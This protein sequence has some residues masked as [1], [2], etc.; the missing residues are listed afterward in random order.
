[1][2]VRRLVLLLVLVLAGPAGAQRSIDQRLEAINQVLARQ[3][4][5]AGALLARGELHRERRDFERALADFAAAARALPPADTDLLQGMTLV[6]AGRAHQGLLYLDRHLA[7]HPGSALGYVE[8]A[9]A[10]EAMVAKEAAADDYQ[11]ALD[12]TPH[13][14]PEQY[15]RRLRLQLAAGRPEAA[16]GGLDEGITELG[17]LPALE[18]PAITLELEARRWEQ[19]LARLQARAPSGGKELV[20]Q[21]RG[22]ILLLAGRRA[23]AR[24]AFRAALDALAALPPERR[25]ARAPLERRLRRQ[26]NEASPPGAGGSSRPRDH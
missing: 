11:R 12:L 5:N 18:D 1:M 4:G 7:R 8:R 23:L 6:D 24:Q 3:P 21:R 16:L 13:R 9:R 10:N 15:L 20:A 22:E 14:S 26:L 17:P 25:A 2:R 19:A